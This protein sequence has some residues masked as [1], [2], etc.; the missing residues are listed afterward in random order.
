MAAPLGDERQ[1]RTETD[2]PASETYLTE[3]DV[4]ERWQVSTK[5]VRRLSQEGAL[6]QTMIRRTPRY[7]LSDV[8]AYEGSQL[9]GVSRP[10]AAQTI[11]YIVP[12]LQRKSLVP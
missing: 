4:A 2:R 8:R 12:P 10:A 7:A 6:R 1:T 5:T 9:R 11:E 3:P